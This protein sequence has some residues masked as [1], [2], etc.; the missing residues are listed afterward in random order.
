ME[1]QI[2]KDSKYINTGDWISYYSFAIFDGTKL[3]LY[4]KKNVII[5]KL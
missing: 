4:S 2:A 1:I 3:H 5:S